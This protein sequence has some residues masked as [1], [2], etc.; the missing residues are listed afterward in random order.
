MS[1]RVN[2]DVQEARMPSRKAFL[3]VRGGGSAV[4]VDTCVRS[5]VEAIS[6]MSESADIRQ[7]GR[8]RIVD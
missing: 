2:A 1:T 4:V 8:Q 7:T 3:E 6:G 5:P